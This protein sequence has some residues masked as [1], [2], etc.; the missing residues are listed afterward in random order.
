MSAILLTTAEVYSGVGPQSLI[1]PVDWLPVTAGGTN[2][3]SPFGF[4]RAIRA[5]VAGT[6]TVTTP[7]GSGRVMNFAA[8]ETRYGIFLAVTAATATGIEGGI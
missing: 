6:I 8:G 2:Q 7:G 1:V 5:N 3:T 4:Y